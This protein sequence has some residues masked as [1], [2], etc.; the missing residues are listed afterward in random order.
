MDGDILMRFRYD[1]VT[2]TEKGGGRK[3]IN[4]EKPISGAFKADNSSIIVDLI[5]IKKRIYGKVVKK[6]P[7]LKGLNQHG[8]GLAGFFFGYKYELIDRLGEKTYKKLKNQIITELIDE[9]TKYEKK[10]FKDISKLFDRQNMDW[11]EVLITNFKIE[12]VYIRDDDFAAQ[13]HKKHPKIR[14]IHWASNNIDS[15]DELSKILKKDITK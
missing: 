4:L 8:Y 11:N 2:N 13:I 10:Y 12:K 15:V 9:L 3:W 14:I 5:N 6:Y 1:A 7:N